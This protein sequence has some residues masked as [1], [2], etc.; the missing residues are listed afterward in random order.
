MLPVILGVFFS[1]QPLGAA[2]LE[3]REVKVGGVRSTMPAAVRSSA[4]KASL[5][6]NVL[7]WSQLFANAQ[8]PAAQYAGET[9]RVT[10]FVFRDS[11]FATDQFLVTRF[12][13][14]CCVADASVSGL[15][16][17]WPDAAALAF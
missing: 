16:V 17:R 13:V 4:A 9:A 10:G 12:L 1:P 2:A 14:S 15:V 3:R 11:R 6:K 5:D 8:D 7:D